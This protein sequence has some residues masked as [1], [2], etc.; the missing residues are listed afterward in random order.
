MA[1][2]C[3]FLGSFERD[4]SCNVYNMYRLRHFSCSLSS[5]LLATESTV[6][7][8]WCLIAPCSIDPRS[9]WF[10]YIIFWLGGPNNSNV[11]H[12]IS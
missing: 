1:A 10:F 2:S 8:Y 9:I 7:E 5:V 6:S 12:N 11:Q 4:Y 3:A